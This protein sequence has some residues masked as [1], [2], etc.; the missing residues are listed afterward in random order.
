MKS[1]RWAA[2]VLC[3]L[4]AAAQIH[5]P[6]PW[7]LAK[8]EPWQA[9]KEASRDAS[10]EARESRGAEDAYNQGTRQLDRGQYED[11]LHSF[12]RVQSGSRAEGALYWKAYCLNKLG[13]RTEAAAALAKLKQ[14]YPK[15][16]WSDDASALAGEMNQ[17][18]GTTAA[19]DATNEEIKLMAI[20]GLLAADPDRAVPQLEK[21]LNGPS[22]PKLKDRALFVLTQS[23]S[24]RAKEVLLNVAKGTSHPDLQMRAIRYI[25]MSGSEEA[26]KQ[27]LEIYNSSSDTDVKRS[28]I[29]SMLSSGASD[30][31]LT[32]AQNEKDPTLRA[33]AIRTLGM[34]HKTPLA[35]YTPNA[36]RQVKKAIINGLFIS[37][38]AKGMIELARKESDPEMK[39]QLVSQLAVMHNKD[40]TDYMMEILK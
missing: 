34:M 10:R 4:P 25:G 36:D 30:Q 11:A 15:S 18:R 28:I 35:L 23:G 3:A 19:E 1:I 14:E 24:P 6:E 17:N 9:A 39:K 12:D 31:L 40:A 2:V 21:L 29:R 16:R 7:L 8:P 22:S 26:R 27:M 20:N 33:E 13:R 38:D 5:K 32:M 37:G